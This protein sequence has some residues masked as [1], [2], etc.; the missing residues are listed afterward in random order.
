[1]NKNNITLFLNPSSKNGKGKK[2]WE[3]FRAYGFK[4]VISLSVQDMLAKTESDENNTAVAVG[5]DGTINLVINGI[6]RSR[7][8]KT[9]GVLYSGTSPDFCKFHGIPTEPEDSL[10]VLQRGKKET[11]DICS[12][13]YD[14]GSVFYFASGCNIGLGAVTAGTSNKIR[15]YCGDFLGTFIGALTAYFTNPPFSAE[16]EIDGSIEKFEKVRHIAVLKNKLIAS[17]LHFNIDAKPGDGHIY[18]IAL[19]KLSLKTIS[20][21]YKGKIPADAYVKKCKRVR[22][23]TSPLQ[24]TEYDGDPKPKGN[25][26]ITCLHKAL[27]LI[28]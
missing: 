17:G 21:V 6:M 5:G 1:M 24:Q 16:A 8:K 20:D 28:K 22:I 26:E 9:L 12:I 23:K 7:A 4:E 18:F 27:E 2:N 3:Y 10:K 13:K 11:V 15:K 25:V 19:P 14:D